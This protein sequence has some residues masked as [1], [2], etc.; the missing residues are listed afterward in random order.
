MMTAR[1]M[2]SSHK[3]FA[4][5]SLA[6]RF[7]I[8]LLLAQ[9]VVSSFLVPCSYRRDCIPAPTALQIRQDPPVIDSVDA[10]KKFITAPAKDKGMF[11]SG[12]PF[13]LSQQA[14]RDQGLQTLEQSVPSEITNH[15]DAVPKTVNNPIF[16]DR[17]SQ[18]FSDTLVEQGHTTVTV[19]LRAPNRLLNG[20]SD[21]FTDGR[22][23]QRS[24]W[25]E[26]EFP[27][28]QAANIRVM[29]IHPLEDGEIGQDPYEIWPVD[30]GH[31]WQARWGGGRQHTEQVQCP[32]TT[33][34]VLVVCRSL[35]DEDTFTTACPNTPMTLEPSV[36]GGQ[37]NF[38]V[39]PAANPES[40]LFEVDYSLTTVAL[41]L[42]ISCFNSNICPDS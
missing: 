30:H 28:M 39:Q 19:A 38:T 12:I 7:F 37:C 17:F 29:A 3:A 11:W 24:D 1:N 22:M 42:L 26:I 35:T 23:V 5:G 33:D 2:R 4:S 21:P 14:A 31:E 27:T 8:F 13:E 36:S 16:W 32:A 40:P 15:P 18:A 25:A 6:Q 10:A 9:T 20:P 34:A 41:A